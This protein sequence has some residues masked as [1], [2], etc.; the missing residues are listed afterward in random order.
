MLGSLSLSFIQQK[1]KIVLGLF[2]TLC[3]EVGP[4]GDLR[5]VGMKLSPGGEDPLCAPPFFLSY[6]ECSP[7]G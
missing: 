1:S 7:L 2:L 4:R 6:S 3:G 5:S